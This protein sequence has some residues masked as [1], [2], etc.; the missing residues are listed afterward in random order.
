MLVKRQVVLIT[1][2]F[3]LASEARSQALEP[4]FQHKHRSQILDFI[5]ISALE[6][7]IVRIRNKDAAALAF[8]NILDFYGIFKEDK[9]ADLDKV[10]SHYLLA[11][12][13]LHYYLIRSHQKVA[14]KRIAQARTAVKG[15]AS[16]YVRNGKD[17]NK[18][19][20][21]NYYRL[22]AGLGLR[23]PRAS[24]SIKT[25]KSKLGKHKQMQENLSLMQAY[26][27][28]QS[29]A[30][31]ASARQ[32][33]KR[34]P[35]ISVFG[36]I[37]YR[38]LQA[39]LD[40]G[41]S[42][43]GVRLMPP[44]RDY[45][46]HLSFAV[47][48]S[49]GSTEGVKIK[50]LD[51]VLLIWLQTRKGSYPPPPF[52]MAGLDNVDPV[53]AYSEL[54]ALALYRQRKFPQAL[55]LYES[56]WKSARNTSTK[57]VIKERIWQIH[58]D[59]YKAN[60]NLTRL[61]DAFKHFHA[62][63]GKAKK[64]KEKKLF[65]QAFE[66]YQSVV[67][68]LLDRA[69]TNPAGAALAVKEAEFFLEYLNSRKDSG[70]LKLKL[71]MILEA[72]GKYEK[73][74][75]LYLDLAKERPKEFLP[76]AIRFQSLLAQ[77][78]LD[79]PWTQQPKGAKV[80]RKKLLDIY[81]QS[82]NSSTGNTVW[83]AVSHIGLL[84]Q[85]IGKMTSA[86]NIW[87][88]YIQKAAKS[89][90]FAREAG[91]YLLDHYY[92][93]KDWIKLISL[94]KIFRDRKIGI[95][96]GYKPFA[97]SSIFANALFVQAQL[98]FKKKA[99]GDVVGNLL[100]F[101]KSFSSDP[102]AP[103]AYH[104]LALALAEQGKAQRALAI[105]KVIA[106]TFPR[107]PKQKEVIISGG[108]LAASTKGASEFAIYFYKLFLARYP[109]DPTV[110]KVRQDLAEH[111]LSQKLYGWAS[112]V[113]KEQSLST[114]TPL[115][116]RL[117]AALKYLDTERQFGEPDDAVFGAR[118]VI[119]LANPGS[120]AAVKAYEFLA[121]LAISRNDVKEM[122]DLETKLSS[123]SQVPKIRESLALI[124]F[125]L[126]ELQTREIV[127]Q[128]S[129]VIIKS[130]EDAVKAIYERFV[131]EK[132]HYEAVCKVGVST[133]CA[134]S[135][136]RLVYLAQSALDVIGSIKIAKTLNNERRTNGFRVFQQ[137]YLT[138]V[139]EVAMI[140]AKNALKLAEENTTTKVW[141]TEIIKNLGNKNNFGIRRPNIV[142]N[143]SSVAK[144]TP[145]LD[146]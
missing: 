38:L 59:E 77:W 135:L 72:S 4:I 46:K 112:E 52:E 107:Y 58:L 57:I 71:A 40:A 33:L 50:I 55:A 18:V 7:E 25:F 26:L 123:M 117:A 132:I 118:Q 108:R 78:P 1:L 127:N 10:W 86:E 74:V 98:D 113:Y 29:K 37:A 97:Y 53:A 103:Q 134:P 19:F 35:N 22:V 75:A 83:L 93:K 109:K 130:P 110:P 137:L 124:K 12:G 121:F 94:V 143:P 139:E 56:L 61:R 65:Q 60:Q 141:K 8:D 101:I 82:L 44:Q 126:A 88:D 64:R 104:M 142:T 114:Q 145:Q 89:N 116:M 67:E 133:S 95:T 100:E 84:Y 70:P 125:R 21:A 68:G 144:P 9:E 63:Y 43:R 66:Q 45:Q 62:S 90:K 5:E 51:T 17:K 48:V 136:L 111:Y 128:Q 23:K 105:Y 91:G 39:M 54:M 69:K 20:I 85:S 15:L 120:D 34:I 11:A 96:K 138:K 6:P 115:P 87:M 2:V 3:H 31:V 13:V 119:Q 122:K 16:Y 49:R 27:D 32:A 92:K 47:N 24:S 106:D 30:S 129:N 28:G 131:A 42:S 102:R 146:Q 14:P 80:H 41:L 76:R 81:T 36:R 73:A 79:P 99:Y 140:Y